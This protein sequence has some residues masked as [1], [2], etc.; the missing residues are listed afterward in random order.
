G[1]PDPLDLAQRL[2]GRR[3]NGG[4]RS[5]VA[6]QRALQAGADPRNAVEGALQR[7]LP[8]ALAMMRDREAVGFVAN[9]LHEVA[10]RAPRAEQDRIFDPRDEDA[11]GSHFVL[12]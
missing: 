2:G 9:P 5:E 11:F 4:D 3:S 12:F 8:T 7:T 6:D 1:G 10:L